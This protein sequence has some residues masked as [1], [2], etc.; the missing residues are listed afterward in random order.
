MSG[1]TD[2]TRAIKR[3]WTLTNGGLSSADVTFQYVP[4]APDAGDVSAGVVESTLNAFRKNSGGSINEIPAASRGTNTVTITGVNAFSEWTLANS[5]SQVTFAR[6][7]SF[8]AINSNGGNLLQWETSY[9][10]DNLGFNLYRS[11]G[12]KLVPVT[13]SLVAGSALIAGARTTLTAGMSY[14]WRDAK[15]Q[16]DSQYY[17]EDIDLN[18]TRTMNGPFTPVAVHDL[19]INA[20]QQAKLLSE[21]NSVQAPSP[22]AVSGWPAAMQTQ[23]VQTNSVT[24]NVGKTITAKNAIISNVES[25]PFAVQRAIAAGQA[26]KL[27]V[28]KAGWYRVSQAELVAAGLNA[29]VDPKLLQL[30]VDGVEQAILVESSNQNQFGPDAYIEFYGTGMDTQ[31]TNAHTYWLVVGSQPGKRINGPVGKVTSA[32]IESQTPGAGNDGDKMTLE[33][34]TTSYA[35]TLERKDRTIYFAALLNGD[36]DNFFGSV[37]TSTPADQSLALSNIDQLTSGPAT[38]ELSLQ[39]ATQQAHKVRVLFNGTE[40]GVLSFDGRE[41]AVEQFQIPRTQLLEGSNTITL[42]S[43]GDGT[44]VSLVDYMHLTYNHAYRADSDSLT[45]SVQNTAPLT[46]DG[47]T[48]SHIRVFDITDPNNVKT[49]GG[50]LIPKTT[51]YAFKIPGGSAATRILMALTDAQVQHV[52]SIAS[53]EPSNLSASDNHADFVLLTHR[54]FRDAIAPLADLRRSQGLDTMVVNVEDVYDEF[55]F[56]EPSTQA[57]KDFLAWT[58]SN[59]TKSPRYVLLVGD[60]SFDPRNY[61]KSTHQDF[62][63]TRMIDTSLLTTASD[64]ALVD[65]NSDGIADISIGRLPAQTVEQAQKMVAKITNYVPGQTGVGA[66]LVS[67]HYE[68]Y[69]F[70]TANS[71]VRALLPSNMPVMVVN[72][73]DRSPDQVRADII[74]GI[75]Q[76]PMIVNYAGHGSVEVWT[77]SGILRSA[78]ATSLTNGQRVPFFVTMTCLNGFFQ[79]VYTESLAEALMKADNGGAVAVWASSGLTEP[80]PQSLVDQQLMR[81][82]FSDAGGGV[83]GSPM[84]GDAVREAKQATTDMDVRRTW[85]FFGDP[86]MRLR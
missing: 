67:D 55:N 69:D 39:G 38:L 42:S 80:D 81:L 59:W 51:G 60:A 2:T 83:G 68:G 14:S 79:D 18:G 36:A 61:L 24:R 77:G 66:L 15:G 32:S 11:E 8:S 35:Y 50:K 22:E 48:S 34:P 44:D 31:S 78:D 40:V 82:L 49:L 16:P 53:N 54:N 1:L 6:L 47:F 33:S 4:G 57:V 85:I 76:G 25:N 3:V 27:A 41:H 62:V 20:K 29:G 21:I 86:T 52:A 73:G 19:N 45:F 23:P 46:I 30:Y 75:D 70:E 43:I 84:L 64:D 65:F 9:E 10:V 26:M 37:V 71:K 72:R 28:N 58:Q 63:P 74:T 7:R 56:G 13:P 5:G 12:G 17:L